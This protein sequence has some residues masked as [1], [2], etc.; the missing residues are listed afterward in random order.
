MWPTA[1]AAHHREGAQAKAIGEGGHVGGGVHHPAAGLRVGATLA[2]PVVG[3]AQ[4]V[5]VGE[6]RRW[7][8]PLQP[9][10]GRTMVEHQRSAALWPPG[11]EAKLSAIWQSQEMLAHAA[12]ARFCVPR[13]PRSWET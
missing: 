7:P 6:E 11:G 5:V 10:A 4:D 8:H 1:G 13:L 12:A 9:A 2:G 3:D